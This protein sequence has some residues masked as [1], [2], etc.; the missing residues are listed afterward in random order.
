MSPPTQRSGAPP[1]GERPAPDDSS[2]RQA[3]RQTQGNPPARH[4]VTDVSVFDLAGWAVRYAT[5]ALAVLPLHSVRDD[6]CTCGK[7][8][9][10]PGKH[11]LTCNGKDDATTDPTQVTTWWDRWPWA[12]I[13]IRPPAGVIVLDVDPR[14]GGATALLALARQH[15]LLPRTLTARTGSGGL[16]IWLAYAGRARGQLCRGVDVKT[17][18]GYVV[19]PPS[20]HASGGQ[21]EWLVV[22]PTALAPHWIRRLLAPSPPP[23]PM[24]RPPSTGGSDHRDAGLIRTVADAPEGSRNSVLH[25]AACRA[26]ER[27]SPPALLAELLAA[28]MAAGL[29]E[30]EA[31][32]TIQSAARSSQVGAA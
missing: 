29:S 26:H 24:H 32:Q 10:S 23:L 16:H 7:A 1:P 21:Y 27:G 9:K 30:S 8:C 28:A 12:N 18:S 11:P 31:R 22:M 15:A 2:R 3:A 5:S 13:G 19:A 4:A 25:W 14:N 6:R 20:L 17:G